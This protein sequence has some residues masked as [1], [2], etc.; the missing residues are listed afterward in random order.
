MS[1]PVGYHRCLG[2]E[3]LASILPWMNSNVSSLSVSRTMVLP[4]SVLTKIWVLLPMWLS[5]W[6]VSKVW[7]L[8]FTKSS[9]FVTTLWS[10]GWHVCMQMLPFFA[11]V[12]FAEGMS[13]LS[14]P[15]F[16]EMY[17]T[18]SMSRFSFAFWDH[19]VAADSP[20]GF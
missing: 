6:S 15:F 5:F 4:E 10:V 3:V 18:K 7:C 16:A 20:S 11:E 9:Q 1:E 14:V 13:R 17:F 2:T 8:I 12:C 19:V